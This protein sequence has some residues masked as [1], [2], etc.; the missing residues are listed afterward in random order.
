MLVQLSRVVSAAGITA[1]QRAGLL[2]LREGDYIGELRQD[3]FGNLYQWEEGMDGLGNPIGF[4]KFIRSGI[5]RVA[6]IPQVQRMLPSQ[7]R[8]GLRIARQTGL[9]GY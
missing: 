3:A 7:V 2:G 8:T 1:A 6:S 4:W 5:R 9:L